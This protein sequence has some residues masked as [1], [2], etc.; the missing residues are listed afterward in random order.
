MSTAQALKLESLSMKPVKALRIETALVSFL[1]SLG[2][3]DE[4]ISALECRSRDGFIPY[5][6]DKGG[7]EAIAFRD[8]A[9]CDQGVGTEFENAN[10]TLDKY[11]LF[12]VEMYAKEKNLGAYET[13][14]DNE[15]EAFYEWRD[16]EESTVLFS[17][18]LMLTSENSLNVRMCVCVKDAPYHRQYDDKLEFDITFNTV[19]ELKTK[20]EKILKKKAVVQFIDNVEEAF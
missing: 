6:H 7:F 9:S 4:R 20:L 2:Y 5:G 13:W 3:R 15:Q 11:A 17:T 19:T 14:S 1:E 18:D 16:N 12:D 10:A 8:Q